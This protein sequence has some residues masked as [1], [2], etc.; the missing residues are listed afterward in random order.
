M[1]RFPRFRRQLVCR[2][3]VALMSDYLDGALAPGDARRLEA[4]LSGCP[5]CSEYLAQMEVTIAAA[6]R[7]EP[8]DLSSEALDDL[9]GLYRSWR[10]G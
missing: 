7:V 5:H 8:D 9:V 2:R 1:A 4:H 10:A 3:A 6:G